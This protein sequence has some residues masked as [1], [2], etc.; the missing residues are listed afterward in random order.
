MLIETIKIFCDLADLKSFS[1]AAQANFI[2]QSAVSQQMRKLEKNWKVPLLERKKNDLVLTK[3]G[4]ILYKEGKIIL[5]RFETLQQNLGK[6]KIAVSGTVRVA[7]IHGVGL[8]ELPPYIK[9]FIGLYPEVNVKL[10]Y[11]RDSQV[12]NEVIQR[13]ADLGVVAFPRLIPQIDV[14]SFRKDKLAIICH[15]KHRLAKFKKIV[16]KKINGSNFVS[17]EKGIPTRRIVDQFLHD[18]KVEIKISMEFDNIETLKKAVEIDAGIS[19]LPLVTVQNEL[20]HKTLKAVEISG[21]PLTRPL[22]II[23]SK[24]RSLPLAVTKFINTLLSDH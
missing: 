11:M 13:R 8:H 15:P 21:K 6:Q 7:A 4:E 19:I 12:Y 18:H 17:F 9:K 3:E 2:T 10:E 23:T 20:N 16:I 22:G 1:K 5:E 24:G 14:V